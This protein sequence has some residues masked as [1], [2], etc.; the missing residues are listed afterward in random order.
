MRASILLTAALFFA[1]G[2]RADTIFYTL[3]TTIKG[4]KFAPELSRFSGKY[5]AVDFRY[6]FKSPRDAVSGLATGK[7]QHEPVTLTR[8]VAESSPQLFGALAVNDTIKS[9]T[10]DIVRTDNKG[11]EVLAYSIR[12]TNAT[13]VAISQHFDYGDGS[14]SARHVPAGRAGLYED[15]SF[16]FQRIEVTSPGAKTGAIDDWYNAQQ[17]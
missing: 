16:V 11:Q 6:N 14:A 10:I 15:V 17:P 2:A 13:V 12:L 3:D 5:E 4:V 8:L 1:S 9:M 7:R